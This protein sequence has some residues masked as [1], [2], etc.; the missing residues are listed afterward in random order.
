MV[1]STMLQMPSL[2]AS[3]SVARQAKHA[4]H[5]NRTGQ[6]IAVL[7]PVASDA[8]D[9]REL[10]DFSTRAAGRY[11][12]GGVRPLHAAQPRHPAARR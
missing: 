2:D 9:P 10:A 11:T 6:R 3:P 1:P 7:P 5:R 4:E 12:S 8:C